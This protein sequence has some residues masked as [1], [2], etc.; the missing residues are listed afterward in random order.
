MSTQQQNLVSAIVPCYNQGHFLSEA[1]ESILNQTYPHYEIIVI[2]DGSTDDT[3]QVAARY[4]NVRCI[5]K[6]NEGLSAARN[7]GLRASAG[8]YVVFLD[9]DDKLLP[10]AFEA[11]VSCLNADPACA[12]AYGHV[13]L[14][15]SS[16]SPLPSPQQFSID[17]EHYLELL[18][19]NYI[20]TPGAVMYRRS[21]LES[22]GDFDVYV[23]ASADLDLNMRVARNYPIRCHDKVILEYRKHDGNMSGKLELMLKSSIAVLRSQWKHVRGNRKFED[24]L[25]SSIRSTREYYGE[26]M[27]SQ[28]RLNIGARKWGQAMTTA[29]ALLRHYPQGFARHACRKLFHSILN[30]RS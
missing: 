8:A 22:V 9:A 13:R 19:H 28:L 24:A 29:A 5:R 11:G 16:G 25:E 20:W 10:E 6:K 1:I 3:S 23:N 27:V 30:A 26:K 14:V 12:L 18:R 2:D 21:V 15:D 4:A 7:T 17:R